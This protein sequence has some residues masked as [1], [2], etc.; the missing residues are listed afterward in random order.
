MPGKRFPLPWASLG[1][2]SHPGGPL[3][4]PIQCQEQPPPRKPNL[5]TPKSAPGEL[6][7][8]P[9]QGARPARPDLP[10]LRKPAR[11]KAQGEP[12]PATGLPALTRTAP[13]VHLVH[14]KA[15]EAGHCLY[16]AVHSLPARQPG[17]ARRAHGPR[18]GEHAQA[19]SSTG[20]SAAH[21][22]CHIANHK[23]APCGG[24]TPDPRATGIRLVLTARPTTARA[25][26]GL[27]EGISLVG[28]HG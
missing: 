3:A 27:T 8:G 14:L 15:P 19:A 13:E 5:T 17:W 10:V 9:A 25:E 16:L 7:A 6:K 2:A 21:P 23:A 18:A 24:S 1:L 20:R 28:D 22:P 4:S 12:V 11:H 26:P